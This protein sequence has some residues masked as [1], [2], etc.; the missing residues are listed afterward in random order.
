M[1]LDIIISH[2]DTY[3]LEERRLISSTTR[4]AKKHETIKNDISNNCE[5]ER[6]PHT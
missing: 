4:Q 6:A 5:V 3:T 2:K 1:K